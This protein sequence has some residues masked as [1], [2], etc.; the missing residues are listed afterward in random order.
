MF[1]KPY[2]PAAYFGSP[3]WPAGTAA[4]PP[5]PGEGVRGF[6]GQ[7]KRQRK[8][9]TRAPR[10]PRGP[11]RGAVRDPLLEL[12]PEQAPATV[13]TPP[14]TVPVEAAAVVVAPP[15]GQPVATVRAPRRGP[16]HQGRTA[17][18]FPAP[19]PLVPVLGPEEDLEAL[20]AVLVAVAVMES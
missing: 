10:A 20:A 13:A 5:V 15:T 8:P 3:Y 11:V 6:G 7:K 1:G 14:A 12:A 19:E 9:S 4:A 18:T 2:W 16:K 17:P